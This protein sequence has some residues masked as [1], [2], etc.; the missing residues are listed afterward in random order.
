MRQRLPTALLVALSTSLCACASSPYDR[1]WVEG[2]I[3]KGT[4]HAPGRATPDAPSLPPS[5]ASIATLSADDAVAVALWNSSRLRVELARLG[6]SQADLADADALPNP[7]FA[8]LF[9]LGGRQLEAS[10]TY[11]VGALLQRPY[12]VAAAKLD[13][14][15][16]A[17]ALVEVG[18]DLARDVKVAH[19]ELSVAR[20][21]ERVRD[22]LEATWTSIAQLTEARQRAGDASDVERRAAKGEALG[23]ADSARRARQDTAIAKVRL[24]GLLGLAGSPL[25]DDVDVVPTAVDLDPPGGEAALLRMALAARPD[26]RAAELAIEAAGERRGLEKAKILQLVARLDAKPVGSGG[27]PPL[28]L[29][30]GVNGELPIFNWNPGGRR[31]ADAELEQASFRYLAVRDDVITAVRSARIQVDQ[32]VASL[33]PWRQEVIPLLAANV[34]VQTRALKRG[35]DT[36]LLTLESLRRLGDARLRDLDLEADVWRARAA[37]D[38]AVG[39]RVP[40][41]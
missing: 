35:D 23:A 36:Y 31:R 14:E 12:R 30:P 2:E 15:K 33:L 38:R 8:F 18:L 7:A 24:R 19:A 27:G 17:R 37:L 25:G 20:R 5:V 28:V 32:A 6:F 34:D 10:V 16:T 41:A 13:L 26:V 11:P 29:R 3:A 1:A 39:Q 9:P 40:K 21:R 22:E 4:G